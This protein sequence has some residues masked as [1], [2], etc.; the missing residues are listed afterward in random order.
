MAFNDNDVTIEDVTVEHE[1]D[2]ALL[3][4]I[5]GQKIWIPKSHIRD[6]SEVY[7]KGTEGKLVIS[8]WI[9]EQKNLV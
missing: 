4:L 3:C 9:A 1:T 6:E 2:S 7:E 5:D 8:E